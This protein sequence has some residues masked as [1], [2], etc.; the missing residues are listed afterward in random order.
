MSG[1][2]E[3]VRDAAKEKICELADAYCKKSLDK[4]QI[5][6]EKKVWL[7]NGNAAPRKPRE[8]VD[9]PSWGHFKEGWI[10]RRNL[11]SG[12]TSLVPVL[13]MVA[14]FAIPG[15]HGPRASHNYQGFGRETQPCLK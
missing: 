8:H 7:T 6:A 11:G 2:K 5:E 13:S 12:D 10:A 3:E 14:A 15:Q 9:R 4:Q 1:F